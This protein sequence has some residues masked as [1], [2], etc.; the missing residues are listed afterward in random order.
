MYQPSALPSLGNTRPEALLCLNPVIPICANSGCCRSDAPQIVI[1]LAV[2]VFVVKSRQPPAKEAVAEPSVAVRVIEVP[3]VSLSPSAIGY[4]PVEPARV[5]KAVAQVSGRVVE[6][7][8]RLKN[9]E[10]HPEGTVLAR[11]D[12]TD[13]QL[14]LAQAEAALAEL[15]RQQANTRN[16]LSIERRNLTLAE[17]E[18]KRIA[19]LA[20]K[21][22]TSRSDADAAERSMLNSRAAVQNLENNLALIPSQRAVQE[23]KVKQAQRDLEHTTLKAPFRLRVADLAVETD[24]FVGVGQGLFAGDSVD[25]VEIVA[26]LPI[27]AL[28]RLFVGRNLPGLRVDDMTGELIEKVGFH[29]TVRLDLGDV[30]ASWE[31]RFLR[32]S[33]AVD[34]ATRT[35]GVVVAVDDPF[36]KVIP[37]QRPPLSKG[38]FVQVELR[39]NPTPGRLVVPRSAVHRSNGESFLFIADKDNRL[40]RRDVSVL[41]AQ[42]DIAAIDKGLQA[43]ERVVVSDLV[44]AVKGMLLEPSIDEALADELGALQ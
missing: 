26:Q 42:D 21:G 30:T 22:T 11:I 44:P 38:M 17:R 34:P 20:K 25:R 33:D 15:D 36:G 29:P 32:F 8:P 39:A 7:H 16:S 27:S 19:D 6:L 4:G 24:Q 2:L 14:A 28:R 41:L 23:A 18:A 3:S 1:G 10:I 37:G 43:G 40:R 13:Y 9:G 31:A 5:W 35:I 12:P